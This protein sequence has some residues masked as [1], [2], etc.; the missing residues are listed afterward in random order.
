VKKSAILVLAVGITVQAMPAAYAND[1][2]RHSVTLTGGTFS[3][4]VN[5]CTPKKQDCGTRGVSLGPRNAASTGR[6]ATAAFG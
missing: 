2:H 4:I 5:F 1:S 3:A 6:F